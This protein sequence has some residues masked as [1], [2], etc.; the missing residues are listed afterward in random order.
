MCTFNLFF[1]EFEQLE[2]YKNNTIMINTVI[3]K[4][5][6]F[7]LFFYNVAPVTILA[8]KWQRGGGGGLLYKKGNIC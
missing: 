4:H 3:Y 6:Q 1:K 2:R 7:Q 5:I 8:G